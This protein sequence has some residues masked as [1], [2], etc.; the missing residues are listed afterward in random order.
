MG[1]VGLTERVAGGRNGTA[2][3]HG[4]GCAG[5]GVGLGFK[6]ELFASLTRVFSR[7]LPTDLFPSLPFSEFAPSAADRFIAMIA[8]IKSFLT[9]E[10]KLNLVDRVQLFL[11]QVAVIVHSV[12]IVCFLAG[13][14]SLW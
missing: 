13:S 14:A 7:G 4:A 9:T 8:K 6:T 12:R 2:D 5:C 3:G 10:P 1:A 11:G